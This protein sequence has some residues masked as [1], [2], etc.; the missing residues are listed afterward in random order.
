MRATYFTIGDLVIDNWDRI[1]IV[2]DQKTN[3]DGIQYSILV[4]EILNVEKGGWQFSS[5]FYPL[6]EEN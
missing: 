4:K 6:N 1:C 2:L 3:R 5:D